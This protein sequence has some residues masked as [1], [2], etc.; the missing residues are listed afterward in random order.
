MIKNIFSVLAFLFGALAG[1]G[2]SAQQ[3]DVR[4]GF[5]FTPSA[6][7]YAVINFGSEQGW[8]NWQMQYAKGTGNAFANTGMG[9]INIIDAGY[10]S[11]VPN[12]S[13]GSVSVLETRNWT[14]VTLDDAKVAMNVDLMVL[15]TNYSYDQTAGYNEGGIAGASQAL[16]NPGSPG[17]SN[18][19][20]NIWGFVP[21]ALTH[22]IGHQM[23][24]EHELGFSDGYGSNATDCRVWMTIMSNWAANY[25]YKL[26]TWHADQNNLTSNSPPAQIHGDGNS[27]DAAYAEMAGKCNLAD[28]PSG[29]YTYTCAAEAPCYATGP[30]SAMCPHSY[31]QTQHGGCSVGCVTIVGGLLASANRTSADVGC[32]NIDR[33]PYFSTNNTAI[34]YH[35][36]ALGGPGNNN[37]AKIVLGAL[38]VAAIHT[39]N[40][41]WRDNM[42]AMPV[43]LQQIPTL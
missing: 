30:D 28:W 22:E 13:P 18:I 23:C 20:L 24:G 27:A 37:A 8:I 11:A 4:V 39:L 25:T 15:V 16:C 19:A 9:S 6:T 5:M 1:V 32:P 7:S 26:Y 2:A 42:K 38:Q 35:G 41:K 34:T 14:D 3:I 17:L 40:A 29:Y 43:R 33:I 12:I 31:T 36:Q 21:N 10:M